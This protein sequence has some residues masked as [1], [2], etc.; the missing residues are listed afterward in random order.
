MSSIASY[1]EAHLLEWLIGIFVVVLTWV[2]T[3]WV[4][5]P[6]LEFLADRQR[7]LEALEVHG[8]I[9]DRSSEERVK[10]AWK[11]IAEVAARMMF[12]AQG[13]P[14]IVRSYSRWRKYELALVGRMLNGVHNFIG[15]NVASATWKNQRDA[16]RFALGATN[17]MSVDRKEEIRAMVR[18]VLD[19]PAGEND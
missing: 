4:G 10:E 19:A 15:Q 13:G 7:T 9:S 17:L 6:L 5:K 14:W 8:G 16:V 12:Y 3:N 18:K 2:G 1:F 11:A